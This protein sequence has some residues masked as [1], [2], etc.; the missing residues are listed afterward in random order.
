[1]MIPPMGQA[2]LGIEIVCDDEKIREIAQTL[3]DGDTYACTMIERQ[4]ISK[5]GAGCSAPV[6]C[7]AVV[8]AG[9]ITFRV[10]LG[11]P[12]GTNIMQEKVIKPLSE[13]KNLGE[14]LAKKM[15]DA[16]ALELLE[17]AA[18]IAFKD[19]MPQRL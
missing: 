9:E 5:I 14:E 8:N 18:K 12:D 16:G 15:I 10:M 1:M 6:A 4:F 19:E 7:N 17:D 11:F 2:A 3:K 13:C